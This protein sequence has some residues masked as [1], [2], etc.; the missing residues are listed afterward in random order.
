M[1]A[2][3][4]LPRRR[5]QGRSGKKVALKSDNVD[6]DN[7]EEAGGRGA[8]MTAEELKNELLLDL[9]QVHVCLGN[10]QRQEMLG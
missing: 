4:S 9:A 2:S 8:P 7:E 10:L 3:Y 1:T 6:N 5:R